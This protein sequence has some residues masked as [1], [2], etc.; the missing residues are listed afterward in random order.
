MGFFGF[1]SDKEEINLL[2]KRGDY[3]EN[4]VKLLTELLSDVESEIDELQFDLPQQKS[5]MA[6]KQ[7]NSVLETCERKAHLVKNII[8]DMCGGADETKMLG[9]GWWPPEN[10]FRWAGRDGK[11][12]E[13][14]FDVL[15]KE[16]YKLHMSFFVPQT[17]VKKP[18]RVLV[19]DKKIFEYIPK[20][21]STVEKTISIPKSLTDKGIL[22]LV[23][24]SSFWCP[25]K[26][27]KSLNDERTLSFAF[28]HISLERM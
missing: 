10:N 22:K 9:C 6:T 14:K 1:R 3:L 20:K 15:P 19:N 5:S 13:I 16:S 23:F 24:H 2:R 12:A 25:A 17:L 18:I 28:K 26:I 7:T 4:K 27:D 21:E 11:Y 8:I